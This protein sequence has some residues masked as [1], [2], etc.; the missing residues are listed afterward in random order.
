M[1]RASKIMELLPPPPD[2][3]NIRRSVMSRE[4]LALLSPMSNPVCSNEKV[5]ATTK[6]YIKGITKKEKTW[7]FLRSKG[8]K[9][10]QPIQQVKNTTKTD[11]SKNIPKKNKP[12]EMKTTSV[13]APKSTSHQKENKPKNTKCRVSEFWK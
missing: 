3:P 9:S 12:N 2:F 1:S 6:S 4:N 5:R 13:Q 8:C 10:G 7:K 11:S